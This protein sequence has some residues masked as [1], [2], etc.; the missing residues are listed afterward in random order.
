MA[1]LMK[2]IHWIIILLALGKLGLSYYE[3]MENETMKQGELES[4]KAEKTST[5]K[6]KRD[7][8]KFLSNI[9][10]EKQKIERVAQE[11]EKTQQLLPSEISDTENL[12]LLRKL[13]D[14]VNIK[15]V[16]VSPEQDDTRGFM[17]V[18]TYRFKAKA[19]Y[20]QLLI[21]FEKI[22]ESKR[23]LN[24]SEVSIRKLEQPQ[25]SRFQLVDGN[26]QLEAYKYNPAYKEDR[27]ID[28]IEKESKAPTEVR[29]R[30]KNKPEGGE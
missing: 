2:K 22:S 10:D 1:S 21:M 27:G 17:V 16:S 26:F 25:R 3:F 29:P 13:A 8:K 11:I 19:T 30:K 12:G 14:D 24:V 20:L 6:T 23:I 28:D 7:V 18:R 15:E 9:E 4:A 5:E